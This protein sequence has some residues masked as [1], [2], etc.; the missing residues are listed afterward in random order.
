M[1][2]FILLIIFTI[3]IGSL[4]IFCKKDVETRK[5]LEH[6]N[7]TTSYNQ[8]A[9]SEKKTNI[10]TEIKEEVSKQSAEDNKPGESSQAVVTDTDKDSKVA[11]GSMDTTRDR[12]LAGISVMFTDEDE[13]IDIFTSLEVVDEDARFLAGYMLDW[14]GDKHGARD[15]GLARKYYERGME[16]NPYALISLGY[17]YQYGKGVQVNTVEAEKCFERAVEIL[18]SQES[19]KSSYPGVTDYLIGMLYYDAYGIEANDVIARVRLENAGYAGNMAAYYQLYKMYEDDSW[20]Y[21]DPDKALDYL[22]LA[23]EGDNGDAEAELGYKYYYG[24]GMAQDR[25]MAMRLLEKAV[26]H[27]SSKGCMFLGI[28]YYE[29]DGI[30]R[31]DD[32]AMSLLGRAAEGGYDGALDEM[33]IIGYRYYDDTSDSEGKDKAKEWWK[34]AADRGSGVAEALLLTKYK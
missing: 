31:S 14:E 34:M 12:L 26:L 9:D 27:G 19:T 13:A 4:F 18:Q 1:E 30:M 3:Y 2:R 6:N 5:L 22:K 16:T 24:I 11:V 20:S 32:I 25:T 15:Y 33:V 17:M 10:E 8:S 21:Y 29:G 28:A 7:N 23:V